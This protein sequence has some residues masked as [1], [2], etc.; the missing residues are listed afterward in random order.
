MREK[1]S[2]WHP[3]MLP[4]DYFHRLKRDQEEVDKAAEKTR[5]VVDEFCGAD[6]ENPEARSPD[7]ESTAKA[8]KSRQGSV[9]EADCGQP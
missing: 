4:K 3:V 5:Y 6:G 8:A 9:R 1:T 7:S 2:R